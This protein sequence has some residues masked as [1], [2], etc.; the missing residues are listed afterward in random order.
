MALLPPETLKSEIEHYCKI[1]G[2]KYGCLVFKIV[3]GRV[4][5]TEITE[6]FLEGE[7]KSQSSGEK[8]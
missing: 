5:K 8:R 3:D 6:Y 4:R 2:L 1:R 7:T